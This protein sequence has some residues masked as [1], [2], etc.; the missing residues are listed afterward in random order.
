MFQFVLGAAAAAVVIGAANSVGFK[1]AI[2]RGRRKFKEKI[3][4]ARE[5]VC[6]IDECAKE[7]V[8]KNAKKRTSG[9][10]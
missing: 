9:E 2:N 1:R 6:A 7:R 3:D 5:Y 10:K 8:N 4:Y